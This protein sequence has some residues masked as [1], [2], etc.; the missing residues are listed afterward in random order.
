MTMARRMEIGM[1]AGLEDRKG[2][3]ASNPTPETKKA[4][5]TDQNEM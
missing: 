5:A 4:A 1:Q 2:G 3:S